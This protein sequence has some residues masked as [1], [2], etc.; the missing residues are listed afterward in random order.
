M[1]TANRK[2][3]SAACLSRFFPIS[4]PILAQGRYTTPIRAER[5]RSNAR[6]TCRRSPASCSESA[7]ATVS[8]T[9]AGWSS[10]PLPHA[11]EPQPTSFRFQRES[12][13]AVYHRCG[14]AKQG[15]V[16]AARAHGACVSDAQQLRL[17]ELA[18]EVLGN[19]LRRNVL[20]VDAVIAGDGPR[21]LIRAPRQENET[22]AGGS[23]VEVEEA[24]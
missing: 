9:G 14:T 15:G 16:D 7:A 21:D 3:Q 4:R 13:L 2:S 24:R 23:C 1:N 20:Q 18:P 19:Y 17:P 10:P 11:N 8:G 22:A 5:G 6:R 12:G